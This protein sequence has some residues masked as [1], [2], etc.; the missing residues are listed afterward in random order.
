MH[1]AAMRIVDDERVAFID[2]GILAALA[3]HR[4]H[5]ELHRHHVRDHV[6]AHRNEIA[7][8]IEQHSGKVMA[9]ADRASEADRQAVSDRRA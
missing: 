2:A 3:D 9:A 5:C 8:G 7:G 6:A 4:A 1:C